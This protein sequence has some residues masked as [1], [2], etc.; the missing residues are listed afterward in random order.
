M[1]VSSGRLAAVAQ[2]LHCGSRKNLKLLTSGKT[3]Q[4]TRKE[5]LHMK[6]LFAA[7]LAIAVSSWGGAAL[8]EI[9]CGTVQEVNAEAREVVLENGHRIHFPEN[10]DINQVMQGN[11]VWITYT[12]T[13]GQSEA[14]SVDLQYD[15]CG[16][17]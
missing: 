14:E 8:A 16:P 12:V 11:T 15:Q 7:T 2:T 4:R 13:D 9:A 5:I 6:R 17:R 3:Q 1:L 10:V